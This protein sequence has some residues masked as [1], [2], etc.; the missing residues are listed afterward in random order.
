MFYAFS[1]FYFL[2]VAKAQQMF[3]FITQKGQK[4][5]DAYTFK[6]LFSLLGEDY[7]I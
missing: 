2:V 6:S 1:S 7:R 3:D 5:E 4:Y